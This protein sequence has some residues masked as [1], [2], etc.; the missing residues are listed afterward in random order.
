MRNNTID[1]HPILTI[2][3]AWPSIMGWMRFLNSDDDVAVRWL[4]SMTLGLTNAFVIEQI[5]SLR[6]TMDS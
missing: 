3:G 2:V 6:K 4:C 5:G 1:P